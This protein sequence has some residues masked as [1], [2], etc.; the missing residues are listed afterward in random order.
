MIASDLTRGVLILFL[1]FAV[2]LWQIYAVCFTL[3][4]ASS[5]FLPAQSVTM[6]L[7]V[8]RAGLMA[9]NSLMQQT[10]Q[11][12]RIF[13][14]AA[15][16]ALVG[17]FGEAACYYADSLTFF[18]SAA[19]IATLA[20][21]RPVGP[22]ARGFGAVLSELSEGVRFVLTH[23]AYSFVILSMTAGLFAI[24]CFSA[25]VPVFVR[26]VLHA[27]A[28]LFG[29]IGS[30]IGLGSITGAFAVMKLTRGR[31][32]THMVS[33]GMSGIGLFILLLAAFRNRPVTLICSFAIGV[34]VA[35]IV[36]AATAL[37][38]GETPPE[39]R[40]RVSSSSMA[41]MAMAQ[42]VALVFAGGW[43]ERF[44]IINLFN[45]SAVMLFGVALGG[46]WKLKRMA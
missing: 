23:P 21:Q 43:A 22:A 40:G 29:T 11:L 25:L 18:F 26:D 24:S 1:A 7:L 46:I 20:Y 9:A 19:M 10:L 33:L 45:A 38:Q 2:N 13:S 8:G 5:F 14:P 17:W 15:A 32:R 27:G 3:S 28:Y 34:S 41:M 6:P 42:T 31:A 37:L 12:V 36:V 16:S 35:F 39:M 44:G 30:L 4:C